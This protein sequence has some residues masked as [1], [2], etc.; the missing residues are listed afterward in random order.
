MTNELVGRMRTGR[1][2]VT[3]IFAVES[4][5]GMFTKGGIHKLGNFY[6]D[7][8]LQKALK[9]IVESLSLPYP[10]WSYLAPAIVRFP[11]VGW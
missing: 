6:T 11:H 5:E 3:F 1:T 10:M 9:T 8:L 2:R 7:L 4:Q